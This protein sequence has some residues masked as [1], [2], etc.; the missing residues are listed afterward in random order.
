MSNKKK[1]GKIVKSIIVGASSIIAVAAIAVPTALTLTNKNDETDAASYE[2]TISTNIVGIESYSLNVKE[3]TNISELKSM[4]RAIDGYKISGVYK[5]EALQHEYFDN[6]YIKANSKIYIKF[7]VATF[8][9]KVYSDVRGEV[10]DSED[11]ELKQLESEQ[12]DTIV[13]TLTELKEVLFERE[14]ELLVAK[15]AED[16]ESELKYSS[17]SF[18]WVNARG[19]KVNLNAMQTITEDME[20]YP[21]YTPEFKDYRFGYSFTQS[22]FRNSIQ[23]TIGGKTGTLDSN[24]HYGSKI[25]LKALAKEGYRISEFTV[26]NGNDEAIDIL[27]EGRKIEEKGLVYYEYTI[28]ANKGNLFITYNEVLNQF[29]LENVPDGVI[30][31]KVGENE[32][33]LTGDKVNNG[34]Q[35]EIAYEEFEGYYNVTFGVV[36]A[37][38]VSGNIYSVY[39]DVTINYSYAY[40]Y[41]Y[42]DFEKVES[43][44]SVTGLNNSETREVVIP[45][46]YRGERVTEIKANAFENAEMTR[47][48]I[49]ENI[50]TIGREAFKNSVN[51]T[52]INYN[53]IEADDL[54]IFDRSNLEEINVI[55]SNS[56]FNNAGTAGNGIAVTFGEKVVTIPAGLFFVS[57]DEGCVSEEY[58][59]PN[60]V[61]VSMGNNV[62]QINP[63]AFNSCNNLSSIEFSQNLDLIGFASFANCEKLTNIQIP[64][65][66]TTIDSMAFVYCTKLESITIPNSVKDLGE[67]IFV[68]CESLKQVT[69]PDN[70]EIIEESMFMYCKSLT[71]INIPTSLKNIKE[72]AFY[73]CDLTSI[74]LPASLNNI[75]DYA[76][77]GNVNLNSIVIPSSVKFIGNNCFNLCENLNT[78]TILSSD[79]WK[80]ADAT[81]NYLLANAEEVLVLKSIVDG[82][83]GTN[84]YLM[85]EFFAA[86]SDDE[87]YRFVPATNAD[88]F[89]FIEGTEEFAGTYTALKNAN[90]TGDV[91][92]PDIYKGKKVASYGVFGIYENLI[93]SIIIPDSVTRLMTNSLVREYD[94]EYV[95][96]GKNV[97]DVG[98][99]YGCLGNNSRNLTIVVD[100]ENNIYSSR[101]LSGNEVNCLINKE[102]KTLVQAAALATLPTDGS[103]IKLGIYSCFDIEKEIVIPESVIEIETF[104]FG[105]NERLESV[106]IPNTVTKIGEEIFYGCP[107]LKT[108][109]LGSG[110]TQISKNLF[111]NCTSL[112]SIVI[113]GNVTSFGVD[114]F[115]DCTSLKSITLETAEM[116]SALTQKNTTIFGGM[117][118][119]ATTI[120][121]LKASD[122]ATNSFLNNFGFYEDGNY[123]VYDL[124]N[125]ATEAIAEDECF[126]YLN[127][128]L[129]YVITKVKTYVEN[130][131]IPD[132]I[133]GIPVVRILD[134]CDVVYDGLETVKT[135]YIGKNLTN[136]NLAI[137][138]EL[139]NL[140]TVN[141]GSPS[142]LK[143]IDENALLNCSSLSSIKIP[144]SVTTIGVDAFS[145]CTA[146][147]TVTIE[148]SEILA[149]VTGNDSSVLG[150]LL[151]NAETVRVSSSIDKRTNSFLN[152][153]IMRSYDG[154]NVYDLTRQ[155]TNYTVT[156]HFWKNNSE[157]R[158]ISGKVGDG[159]VDIPSVD[160]VGENYNVYTLD[161]WE[162]AY[163]YEVDL[164]SI[165]YN[166]HI[167]AVYDISISKEVETEDGYI[168]RSVSKGWMLTRLPTGEK[169][170]IIPSSYNGLPVV[171]IAA[172]VFDGA[173]LDSVV[174][175]S[176]VTRIMGNWSFSHCNIGELIFEEG[177]EMLYFNQSK[178]ITFG[179]II[180]SIYMGRKRT[181]FFA[182][183]AIVTSN[184]SYVDGHRDTDEPAY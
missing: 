80:I 174:I 8:N 100:P 25:K 120:K 184:I 126:K 140:T 9:V 181:S 12:D 66:V 158:S 154:Y 22:D 71:S 151:A 145:G 35:L 105:G 28:E 79:V 107:K 44:W 20:L 16:S 58:I 61:S 169:N 134:D 68:L 172:N 106:V 143:I 69:L 152:K 108:V 78:V 114:A 163:G 70:L 26:K 63:A 11:Y 60:V 3:G 52:Q 94:L 86:Y 156:Y 62:T 49:G 13:D 82:D 170:V 1:N 46:T 51:L 99:P 128:R 40:E 32:P 147:K 111:Y 76:F 93:T 18:N 136:L 65:K 67:S 95:Y 110:I 150:G 74:N 178:D 132:E 91:V 14:K 137:T 45:N 50:K 117:I 113:K 171:S 173:V 125:L 164:G 153:Y 167:Y 146:L 157:V 33:L 64:N 101:D 24:Y 176:S 144:A 57:D 135:I 21:S 183:L 41:D 5:D 148:S 38:L 88:N 103:I 23:V 177:D 42:L 133:D 175:P 118:A 139:S 53:A 56:I 7:S 142:S 59:S 43:G 92:I 75:G 34:D 48:T 97:A 119:N 131:I 6:E 160:Y 159:P 2:I 17:I 39:D 47:L 29:T 72:K 162:D 104:A 121:V 168:L 102:T 182:N 84:A 138:W 37:K 15:W 179:S 130:I 129:G 36:G 123:Y 96:F 73:G 149:K 10:S 116:Y 19:E 180:G 27:T 109:V 115:K 112:E 165:S 77:C 155:I 90:T 31:K 127:T 55:K 4:F 122:N 54:F 83:N 81:T 89:T 166:I 141:F 124:T 87:Y 30:V 98:E 161:H 85:S